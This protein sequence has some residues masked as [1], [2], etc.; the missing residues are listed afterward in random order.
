MFNLFRIKTPIETLTEELKFAKLELIKATNHRVHWDHQTKELQTRIREL[1]GM[2]A[3]E[4]SIN[5]ISNVELI[6]K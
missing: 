4:E 3:R 2:K 1:E 5:R 6:G